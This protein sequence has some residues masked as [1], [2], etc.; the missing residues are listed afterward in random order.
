MVM[1]MVMLNAPHI[2]GYGEPK[3]PRTLEIIRPDEMTPDLIFGHVERLLNDIIEWEDFDD[4]DR[5]KKVAFQP[6]GFQHAAG[7]QPAA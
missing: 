5:N 7:G 3:P 6:I 4:D 1:V 2:E